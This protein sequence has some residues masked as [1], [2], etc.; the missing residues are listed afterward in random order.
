MG[1]SVYPPAA[2]SAA[3]PNVYTRSQT[4]APAEKDLTAP[5]PLGVNANSFISCNVL[6][7]NVALT[8]VLFSATTSG[9][10][11]DRFLFQTHPIG[12]GGTGWRETAAMEMASGY[13]DYMHRTYDGAG[14]YTYLVPAPGAND[15][16]M[17]RVSGAIGAGTCIANAIGTHG[18][19]PFPPKFVGKR[20]VALMV[21]GQATGTTLALV[22]F[23]WL[24]ENDDRTRTLT[25]GVTTRPVTGG[26]RLWVQ[27]YDFAYI[28]GQANDVLQRLG[29]IVRANNVVQAGNANSP[30][31]FEVGLHS[32]PG[33]SVSFPE[34]LEL[35]NALGS[36]QMNV[37]LQAKS[38]LGIGTLTGTV[39]G[40][41]TL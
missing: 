16:R 28:P 23:D 18:P 6:V 10:T 9:T 20:D 27:G 21:K 41:E 33:R 2:A 24:Q 5:D 3:N 12:A 13:W 26:K 4:F 1:I 34:P 17:I 38:S 37:G 25:S 15:V 36:N 14:I 39:F 29:F 7:Q 31:K 32:A 40:F 8:G 19:M 30:A 11:G 22:N 35:Q